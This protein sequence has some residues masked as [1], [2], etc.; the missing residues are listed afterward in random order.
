MRNL[1]GAL[2]GYRLIL[3]IFLGTIALCAA[4]G[5]DADA[6]E[7]PNPADEPWPTL[8]PKQLEDVQE[9]IESDDS[10][11]PGDEPAPD[12]TEP[13][14][15]SEPTE[16][17]T[18]APTAAPVSDDEPARLDDRQFAVIEFGV[19]VLVLLVAVH[20][21]GSWRTGRRQ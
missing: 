10:L 21:V 8:S 12:L 15:S 16:A 6:A 13:E 9:Q 5:I 14:P 17:P 11:T 4:L 18:T 2:R 20:V 7:N 3:S 19:G 1:L